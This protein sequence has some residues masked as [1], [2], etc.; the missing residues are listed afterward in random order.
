MNVQE[1]I[2]QKI[3]R[4][5]KQIKEC[6]NNTEAISL[7]KELVD[8]FKKVLTNKDFLEEIARTNK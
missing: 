2:Q 5:Q 1:E 3:N 8:L 4:L 7:Q 6:D